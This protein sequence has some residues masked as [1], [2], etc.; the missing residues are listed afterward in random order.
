AYNNSQLDDNGDKQGKSSDNRDTTV[1]STEAERSK[2]DEMLNRVQHDN[3]TKKSSDSRNT[4]VISTEAER[5]KD[6]EMLNRVQHDND[7]NE[8]LNHVQ[9]DNN[10]T[11]SSG[12]E[13]N[14]A[15]SDEEDSSDDNAAAVIIPAKADKHQKQAKQNKTVKEKTEKTKE[16]KEKTKRDNKWLLW[17]LII[18][19]LLLLLLLLI[20]L[21]WWLIRKISDSNRAASSGGGRSSGGIDRTPVETYSPPPTPIVSSSSSSAKKPAAKPAANNKVKF[22]IAK[23]SYRKAKNRID[24]TK[25]SGIPTFIE[26]MN[27]DEGKFKVGSAVTI[28]EILDDHISAQS[29]TSL[30]PDDI[31][32]INKADFRVIYVRYRSKVYTFTLVPIDPN[33]D[34]RR[35]VKMTDSVT[36]AEKTVAVYGSKEAI[37]NKMLA[38]SKVEIVSPKWSDGTIDTVAGQTDKVIRSDSP[39]YLDY[40]VEIQQGAKSTQYLITEVKYE[41]R[42]YTGKIKPL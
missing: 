18:L 6:N 9:H 1:I 35:N 42:R 14:T 37:I 38:P 5:S 29:M 4:T 17:L 41:N 10:T 27:K 34:I 36:M 31:V 26:E 13:N 24:N 39:L 32:T 22:R 7:D 11:N 16:T 33:Y 8:M 12:D 25:E 2:D 30:Q 20:W 15:V 23:D 3:N 40:I 28:S 19:L 21:I